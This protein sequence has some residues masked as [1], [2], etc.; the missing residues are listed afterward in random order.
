[1]RQ[2]LHFINTLC[3]PLAA[4]PRELTDYAVGGYEP[5]PENPAEVSVIVL[6]IVL[7][8]VSKC[9]GNWPYWKA[10]SCLVRHPDHPGSD[11]LQGSCKDVGR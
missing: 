3:L 8:G 11:P 9:P 10:T 5:L 4:K 1:L 6:I 2:I 7:S